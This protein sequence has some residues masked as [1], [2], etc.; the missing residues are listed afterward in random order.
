MTAN[1]DK[2]LDRIQKLLRLSG[3]NPNPNEAASAAAEAARLMAEYQ[4][5]EAQLAIE[6]K[7]VES[8]G[9][10]SIGFEKARAARWKGHVAAAL[11]RA[12]GCKMFWQKR[13]NAAWKIETHTMVIGRPSDVRT[14]GYTYQAVVAQVEEMCDRTW[15]TVSASHLEYGYADRAER[16]GIARAWK[17]AFKLGAA[18]EI[19]RRVSE[20]AKEK[21]EDFERQ[22]AAA[23]QVDSSSALVLVKNDLVRYAEEVAARE[24]NLRL[25]T[26]ARS[27]GGQRSHDG[28]RQGRE[29]GGK[30]TLTGGAQL[31]AAKQRI[32]GV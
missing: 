32:S 17:E 14:I 8:V 29:A 24:K 10:D 5:E 15:E 26:A 30:V 11:A 18:H 20:A 21:R 22:V 4:I 3:S 27:S 19:V 9:T 1:I 7:R 2:V 12:V 31:G 25:R 16:I 28:Y 23:R 6:E 13:R